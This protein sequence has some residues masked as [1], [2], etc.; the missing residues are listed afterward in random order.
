VRVTTLASGSSGNCTLISDTDSHI[1]VDAGISTRRISTALTSIGLTLCD[2]SAVLVT[3]EHND[4]IYGLRTMTKNYHIPLFSPPKV[5]NCLR[6]N[7]PGADEL[8][9]D[10]IPGEPFSVGELEISAFRTPHD[11]PESVGYVLNGSRTAG[12]CTDLGHVP[13]S[14]FYALE[15]TDTVVLE[16]NHDED[17][18]RNGD[19]PFF[20]KRRI[21]SDNGHLSND[22]CANLAAAL[23]SSGTRRIILAHLSRENNSPQ[24]ARET[25]ARVLVKQGFAP[26]VHIGL[27]IAPVGD[28]FSFDLTEALVCSP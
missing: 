16:A 7:I 28:S 11:T 19:Y 25:V 24:I 20:L 4:H 12:V 23:A 8:L 17:M 9:T 3:H 1:L 22:T 26:D 18:L 2:I 13:D 27:A 5:G 21:F 14:V 10:V 6:W 15:G